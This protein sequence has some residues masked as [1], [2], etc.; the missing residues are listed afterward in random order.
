MK[1]IVGLGNPGLR[2][3]QTRHNLGFWTVDRLSETWQIALTKHKFQAKVGDGHLRGERTMLVKPQTFMNRSGR[4][5]ADLVHFFQ[6]DLADL[7]VIYDDLDLPPG[8]LRIKGSGSS[9][10]HKG[11]SDIIQHLGTDAFARLR[12]GIGQP[13]PLMGAADYVLQG[14]GVE[15]TRILTEA[16]CR[17]AEAVDMWLREGLDA[18]MNHFN[19]KQNSEDQTQPGEGE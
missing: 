7:M 2:Y 9:G 17:G 1:V 19:R 15:E 5:V 3:A 8:S 11:M 4:A 18:A 13:P 6:L 12:L 10:G 14:M 16:V